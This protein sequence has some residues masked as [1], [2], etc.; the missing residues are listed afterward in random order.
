MDH[1]PPTPLAT[2]A[3]V[4]VSLAFVAE[5]RDAAEHENVD[6]GSVHVHGGKQASGLHLEP[7]VLA[8]AAA[9]PLAEPRGRADDWA[10][11]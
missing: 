1:G 6:R 9:Q 3:R 4:E 7:K 11:R 5:V 8:V 10:R 2:T